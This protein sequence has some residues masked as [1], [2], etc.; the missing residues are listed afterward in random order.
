MKL[1]LTRLSREL[2]VDFN[3][4]RYDA[5]TIAFVV[6]AGLKKLQPTIDKVRAFVVEIRRSLK[7]NKNC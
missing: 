4:I 6:N 3:V 1:L 5:H 2:Q 7:K